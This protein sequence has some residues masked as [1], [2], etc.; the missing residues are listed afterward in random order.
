M[1]RIVIIGNSAAGI[2]ASEAIRESDKD[3][4]VTIVSDEPFVAYSA[5]KY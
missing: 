4:S 3:S 1:K 5:I 2:A